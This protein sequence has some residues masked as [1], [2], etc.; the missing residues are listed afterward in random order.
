M[1]YVAVYFLCYFVCVLV[2]LVEYV[3]RVVCSVRFKSVFVLSKSQLSTTS[4]YIIT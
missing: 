1:F 2:Y 4:Y 3:V